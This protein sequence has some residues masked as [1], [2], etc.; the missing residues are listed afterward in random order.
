MDIQELIKQHT[1]ADG[2]TDFEALDK[3]VKFS[4][5]SSIEK[6]VAEKV[7]EF[8][9]EM[10]GLKTKNAELSTLN[11]S[12]SSNDEFYKSKIKELTN[13]NSIFKNQRSLN[14]FRERANKL[15][16][17]KEIQEQ[18]IENGADLDKV[19]LNAFQNS[20]TTESNSSEGNSKPNADKNDIFAFMDDPSIGK[21][22][23]NEN[24]AVGTN[25]G[26]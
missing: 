11:T 15:G 5:E 19:N 8:H 20:N 3:E 23:N 2:V 9:G 7:S 13:E 21:N 6:K 25:K 17:S 26:E 12:L 18:F 22:T 16:V 10:N 14:D 1:N 24:G 4:I